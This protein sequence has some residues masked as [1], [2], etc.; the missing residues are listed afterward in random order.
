MLISI[1]L[2][3]LSKLPLPIDPLP[4]VLR[5]VHDLCASKL[6]GSQRADEIDI[7]ERQFLQIQYDFWSV[8]LNLFR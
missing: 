5:T 2:P 1:P 4:H 8:P 3:N 6:A 7:G